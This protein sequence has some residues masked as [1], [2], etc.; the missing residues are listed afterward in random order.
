MQILR[1]RRKLNR[2]GVGAS[3]TTGSAF[4]VGGDAVLST[5]Y[6]R[7]FSCFDAASPDSAA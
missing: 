6:A 3:A 4:L 5:F 1:W 2:E 7:A